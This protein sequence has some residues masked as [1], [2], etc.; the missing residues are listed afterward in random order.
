MASDREDRRRALLALL[1]AGIAAFKAGYAFEPKDI[2]HSPAVTVHSDGSSPY[3]DRDNAQWRFIVSLWVKRTGDGSAAEDE[4]DTL[5]QEAIRLIMRGGSGILSSLRVNETALA[6]GFTTMDYPLVN[7][8]QY[9]RERI[10]V[11]V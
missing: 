10:P 1:E 2:Q 11:T 5:S 6:A 9:R 3:R 7:G 4:I 8:M